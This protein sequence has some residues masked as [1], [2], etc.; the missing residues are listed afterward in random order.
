M[1]CIKRWSLAAAFGSG[2]QV[3]SILE[4]PVTLTACF[5]RKRNEVSL[6][7]LMWAVNRCNYKRYMDQGYFTVTDFARL[8]G[9]SGSKPRAIAQ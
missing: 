9:L 6:I 5:V 7:R 2:V 4:N 3:V 1:K 8:R